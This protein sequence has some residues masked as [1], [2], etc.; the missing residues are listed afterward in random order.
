MQPDAAHGRC[1][2]GVARRVLLVDDHPSFR[3]SA[4]AL[5]AEEGFEVVAEAE[6]GAAALELAADRDP[7]LVLLDIQ[8]PDLDGFEV[9]LR[10]LERHPGLAIVLVSTRE[11]SDYGSLIEQSGARG[12]VSKIDLAGAVLDALL[13]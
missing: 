5:L 2:D 3:R 12:F 9:A 6:D 10:L 11:R 13:A 4:R 7:E 8:L 1:P